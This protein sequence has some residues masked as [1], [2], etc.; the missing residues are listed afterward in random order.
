MTTDGR[1]QSR[2]KIIGCS[3]WDGALDEAFRL[4]LN[5]DVIDAE[6]IVQHCPQLLEQRR[7]RLSVV[8]HDVGGEGIEGRW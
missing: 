5:G 8:G 7:V 3:N 6:P 1:R 4:D 2:E